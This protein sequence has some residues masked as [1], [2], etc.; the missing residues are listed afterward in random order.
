MKTRPTL[1]ATLFAFLFSASLLSAGEPPK[2]GPEMKRLEYFIGTWTTDA[3]ALA[4][5]FGP[6]GKV[7]GT[8]TYER[9]PGGFSITLRSDG[10][11]PGGPM[12]STA[13]IAWDSVKQAYHYHGA[14][15][16]GGLGFATGKVDGTKWTWS[17]EDHMDGKTVKGR[18]TLVELPPSSYTYKYEMQGDDGKYATVEEGK[19]SK[20]K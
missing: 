6:A 18:F 17:T 14:N 12:K 11:T 4:S 1:A 15:S 10:K 8:E 7:T 3:N 5:P 13:I 19:V 2:P 20:N 16:V 9:G